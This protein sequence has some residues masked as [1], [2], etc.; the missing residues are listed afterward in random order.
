MAAETRTYLIDDLATALM[1]MA[2][3]SEPLEKIYTTC[4]ERLFAEGVPLWRSQLAYR[5]LHPLYSGG[6][7]V[8][9]RDAA[10]E[11]D[12]F[13]R[14][15]DPDHIT[16]GFRESPFFHLI[17]NGIPFLR[18]RL[19]GPDALLD[20]NVLPNL[21]DEGA[22]DYLA[23]IVS[24]GD[25]TLDGMAVSFAT[26][27][28]GG[29][30]DAQVQHLL[31]I[32]LALGL[33]CKSVI[34]EQIALNVVTA[35]LG[36]NAGPRVLDGRIRRGDG[37][38]IRA[39]LWYA[40]LRASTRMADNMPLPDF[41][42]V[43]NSYFECAAGAALDAGGDISNLAGDAVLAIFPL[44]DGRIGETC[45]RA[46]AAAQDAR[47]RLAGLNADLRAQGR[48]PIAFGL[49]LHIGDVMFGNVGVP[50]R[51][52][53]S[54]IGPSVNEVAR[55]EQ[56]TKTL[57]APVVFSKTFADQVPR[58]VRSLGFHTIRGR[59]QPMEVFGL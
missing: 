33:A 41:L 44:G 11:R 50:E 6:G 31:K 37:E 9:W 55:L 34:R 5:L 36:P 8:W 30:T 48:E 47:L 16:D 13:L 42:Q 28:E 27:E 2:L 24:F 17:I 25:S 26:D 7:I 35:Y 23:F 43:L 39:V 32:R 52:S 57:D 1:A 38:A 21:R 14:A 15:D 20:F 4:C 59:T 10:A 29:F 51:V 12:D 53:F 54:V 3:E 22:T 40:D 19:T 49:A 45:E 58:P 18:R 56:L 46:L